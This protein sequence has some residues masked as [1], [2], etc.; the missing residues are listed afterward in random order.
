[1]LLVRLLNESLRF[2]WHALSTNKLRTFLSLLGVTIGILAVISVF[3]IVDS[4]E[5]NVRSSIDKLEQ[6]LFISKNGLGEQMIVENING[7]IFG[8]DRK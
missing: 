7:G 6:M 2:A 8:K 5:E 4:L 3:T 1:M